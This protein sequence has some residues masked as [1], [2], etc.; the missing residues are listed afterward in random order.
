[1]TSPDLRRTLQANSDAIVVASAAP[2]VL[3]TAAAI[4]IG[5]TVATV[6]RKI[7]ERVVTAAPRLVDLMSTSDQTRLPAEFKHI[8]KRRKRNQMGFP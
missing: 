3:R 1:V 4:R 6:L 8:T 2:R 5:L 7:S